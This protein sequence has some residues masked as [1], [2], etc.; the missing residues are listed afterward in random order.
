MSYR[1]AVMRAAERDLDALPPRLRAV[2]AARLRA[3][4]DNPRPHGSKPLKGALRGSYRVP[5][6]HD[7]RIGDDVDD[8]E[9]VVT[10]WG[11]GHRRS[12]YNLARR[13]RR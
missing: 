3:L 9:R 8:R 4:A 12:F 2:A 1:G 11:I 13:R 7:Y 10:V 6:A 5:V